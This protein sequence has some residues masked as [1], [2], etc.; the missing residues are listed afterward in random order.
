MFNDKSYKINITQSVQCAV[1]KATPEEVSHA[2]YIP[3][4]KKDNMWLYM[5][6]E[7]KLKTAGCL[8]F[9]PTKISAYQLFINL[10]NGYCV[11]GLFNR[12]SPFQWKGSFN[13]QWKGAQVIYLDAD[14]SKVS[15]QE[16]V[17]ALKYKPT[18]AMTT[19]SHMMPG[20]LNRF[21]L[22][23]VFKD[24]MYNFDGFSNFF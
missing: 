12:P 9:C 23:Y 2:D 7:L 6:N 8:T 22:V 4:D 3:E 10:T 11:S 24:V 15:M 19:Q 18:F 21:R 13:G 14:D 20:K 5:N 1:T 17:E 16:T